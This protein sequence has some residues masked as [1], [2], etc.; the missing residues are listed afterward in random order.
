MHRKQTHFINHNSAK[1]KQRS[2]HLISISG[3]VHGH[4]PFEYIYGVD[5]VGVAIFHETI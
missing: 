3:N 4:L 5:D 2:C 1:P